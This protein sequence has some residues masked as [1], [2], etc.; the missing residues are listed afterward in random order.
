[1]HQVVTDR[2][3]VE[4][5]E[6]ANNTFG[7]LRK[8]LEE[9]NVKAPGRVFLAESEWGT[10]KCEFAIVTTA[11]IVK[12]V[13]QDLLFL[14]ATDEQAYV[15]GT[16]GAG[17]HQAFSQDQFV[18]FGEESLSAPSICLEWSFAPGDRLAVSPEAMEAIDLGEG[19]FFAFPEFDED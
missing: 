10:P 6:N 9:C 12:N 7:Y 15:S 19:V 8:Q 5:A 11:G 1:M 16:A 14:R 3:V 13:I 17:F 2:G 4:L 18:W